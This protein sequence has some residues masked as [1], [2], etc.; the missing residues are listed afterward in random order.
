MKQKVET[1]R[2]AASERIA[3]CRVFRVREDFCERAGDNLKGTFF[4]IENP[5]W[6]N[7][8]ALT[9]EKKVVLIEQFRHGAEEITLE[10]PGGMIDDGESP[11]TAARRELAE[12]TG[13][14][15]ENFVFLGKTRPN[16]ALQNN[17]IFH[18]L[19]LDCRK[20]V[21]TNFD[22]HESIA[23]KL[24]ALPEIDELIRDEIIAHSLVLTCF[25]RFEQY[26]KAERASFAFP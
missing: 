1:W 7:V 19:A 4:V 3:D 5:D 10:I 22:E 24:A 20:T 23:V 11:E 14:T 26:Q 21:E 17:R 16:P 6:V 9:E 15:S 8:I 13:Y 2:R 12:E 18:F 25:Y